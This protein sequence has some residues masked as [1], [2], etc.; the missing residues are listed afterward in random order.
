MPEIRGAE[1]TLGTS[2]DFSLTIL[3]FT[4]CSNEI[5][6]V[7]HSDTQKLKKYPS[8][9]VAKSVAESVPPK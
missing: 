1:A 5:K 2:T 7:A 8:I 3:S 4:P 9:P 6:V